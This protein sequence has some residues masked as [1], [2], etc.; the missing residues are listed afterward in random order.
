MKN[1]YCLTTGI[2]VSG[3]MAAIV[4]Q[5]DLWDQNTLRT[6][7]PG[8][9]H[10][11]VEDIWIRF[12]DVKLF[13]MGGDAK[14]IVDE[15]ESIWYPAAYALPQIRPFLFGLMRQVEGERLG[16]VL[17]TKLAPG[18]VITPHVDG[19]SHAA[20]YKRYHLVLQGLPGSNFRS[21]DEWVGMKTGE[22]WWFNNGIEHEVINNSSDDRVHIIADIRS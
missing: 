11:Q 9:A 21:G 13:E 17:I 20:Y 12:N 7:H 2:D 16:R 3:I 8:T 1:F 18:K 22:L 4:R 15:H 5:P 19:G 10:S 6:E 14:T